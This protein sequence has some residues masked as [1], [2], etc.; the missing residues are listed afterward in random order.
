MKPLQSMVTRLISTKR[1]KRNNQMK[2]KINS[3]RGLR[4]GDLFCYNKIL[5]KVVVF[6]TRSTVIGSWI[7]NEGRTANNYVRIPIIHIYYDEILN[8]QMRKKG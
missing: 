5:Y 2:K 8:D 6:P 1:R 4:V 3:V 7:Y